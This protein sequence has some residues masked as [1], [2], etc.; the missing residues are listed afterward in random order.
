MNS[1]FA[2]MNTRDIQ[3]WLKGAQVYLDKA[4]EPARL[5]TMEA[6]KI[7]AEELRVRYKHHI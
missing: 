5:I 2:N 6:I 7:A 1:L 4:N 3:D